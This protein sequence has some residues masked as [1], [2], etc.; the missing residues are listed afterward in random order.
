MSSSGASECHAGGPALDQGPHLE[1]A[2][3]SQSV[4]NFDELI[5]I[6]AFWQQLSA[7][8]NSKI[9]AILAHLTDHA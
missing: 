1:M 6:S 7:A 4:K 5:S 3:K 8:L 9:V 2:A